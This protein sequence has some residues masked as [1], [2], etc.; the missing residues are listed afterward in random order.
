MAATEAPAKLELDEATLE[1]GRSAAKGVLFGGVP[2]TELS[3]ED[4]LSA[5]GFLNLELKDLQRRAQ[6]AIDIMV[7]P[8]PE[9]EPPAEG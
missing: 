5:A 8:E 6:A 1:M 7:G 4:L 2:L 3:H 9:D